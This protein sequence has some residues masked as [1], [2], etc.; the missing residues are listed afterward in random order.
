MAELPTGTVTFL[1]TDIEASTHL[2][3]R[4]GDRYAALL[5]THYGI[6][7]A[8]IAAHGGHVVRPLGDALFAAFADASSALAGA[9]EAQLALAAHPWGEGEEIRVRMG[10]HSGEALVTEDDYVGLAVHQA[11]RICAAAHGLQIVV[12]DVAL[13]LAG[14][15]LPPGTDVRDLGHHRLRDLPEPLRLWQLVHHGLPREF[16]RLRSDAVPGNLPKQITSF[17]GR[18][19]ETRALVDQLVGGT[20]LVTLTGPAGCGKTRLAL[21]VAVEVVDRFPHGAWVVELAPLSDAAGVAQ[22]VASALDVREEAGAP[23]DR[24]LV[25]SLR[26]KELLLVL[27]SC[28]HLVLAVAELA[29]DI[30]S[31]CPQVHVL[32]TTQEALGITGETVV[33]V[34]PLSLPSEDL[35]SPTAAAIAAYEG[36]ELFVERARERRS[37]FVLNDD[38]AASVAHICRR[39][40]G[41]P[42][43]IEL[44]AG[45][46]NILSPSQ[47]ASR[48]DDQFLLLTGGSRTA[49]PR[50][51][52]LRAAVDWSHQLL[53]PEEQAVLRRLAVFIGGCTLEAAEAVCGGKGIASAEVLDLLDRLVA[54]SLVNVE[55]QDGVSRYRLLEI[56]RQYAQERLVEAGEV[57][58]RRARHLAWFT[59]M[60]VEAEPE[61]TGPNQAVWL[62]RLASDDGNLR[63][64][65]EWAASHAGHPAAG[66]P[67]NALLKLAASLWRYWLVRGHWSE[68]RTWLARALSEADAL[69]SD[70]DGIA[71][72]ARGLAAAGDLATEQADLAAAEPLLQQ[73]LTL[74]R[75]I[76]N[77]EGVAKALNHLG[78]LYRYRLDYPAARDHLNQALEMRRAV[79][80]ERGMA[81]SL[82]N[83]GLLAS[84]QRDYE[85]ARAC[86]TEALPLA[87][88]LGDKRV[89]ATLTN[90]LATVAFADGDRRGARRLAE[91]GFALSRELGDRQTI[92]E[93][94]TVLAGIGG[95]DGEGTAAVAML[96]EAL[97]IW[98]ALGAR[99][100]EAASYT[101][102]GELALSAGDWASARAYLD[103][104]VA[105]W[106]RLGD[107]AALARVTNLC[108]WS[109]VMNGE[110][111][112]AAGLLHEAVELARAMG[113]P[114]QLGASLHSLG[115]HHFWTGD[116]E[117]ARALYEQSSELSATAG[118]RN[119]VWWPALGLGIVAREQGDV[120]TALG[121]LR[122][123]VAVRPRIGFTIFTA[124]CLEEVAGLAAR[125]GA[126]D[127][128]A[129]LL[130]RA[131]ALREDVKVAV[132]PVRRP[133]I[134][135][136]VD[137][138][139][140]ALG[141]D[142]WSTT[143]ARAARA[144][145]D[146]L[147]ATALDNIAT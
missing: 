61:L 139:R 27:D 80:N 75:R 111:A 49:V 36:V 84:A 137:A 19:G 63:A 23:V 21:E 90:A 130:A 98:R 5:E 87:R 106:R 79:G 22:A 57:V 40:D 32:T 66:D 114:R 6:L 117:G 102:V 31:R 56:I 8:A 67:T 78:N 119:L 136:W 48:L 145:A 107:E 121:H 58:E 118:W 17:I 126:H 94:L 29:A 54:R 108:G 92:A 74:W 144:D 51:Q 110:P 88:R 53:G 24:S 70:D 4:A 7:R 37:D 113:E 76:D 82:R 11:A 13:E 46:A 120:V 52:T 96:D 138:A 95:A 3:Q 103:A 9:L 38:N 47:I 34:P 65:M 81:V 64:A 44:A 45:R 132:A 143:T 127:D 93:H 39:L 16:P 135:G 62:A 147:L 55:E 69:P 104:A 59:E 77:A 26:E 141:Q 30:L 91:E 89:I 142:R 105:A 73:A 116:L 86:Y 12:S 115:D 28:E 112:V 33:R 41:I 100:A 15:V 134:D 25:A 83:L 2:L 71:L 140:D 18:A 101:T 133:V 43:A 97:A 85:T 72:R 42:L 123:A 1:F 35:A 14:E 124:D 20:R 146:D 60:V 99:D 125:Q 129:A 128:V 131:A 50:Q 68:G 109:A 10:L 122:T